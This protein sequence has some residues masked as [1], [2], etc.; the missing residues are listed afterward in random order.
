MAE[1]MQRGVSAP[2]GVWARVRADYLAGRS[3]SACARLH[4]VGVTT[5]R[6]RA[7]REGWRR[8]DHPWV[9]PARLD[10]ADEAA[11][12][13]EQVGGNLDKITFHDLSWLACRR[14]RRAVMRGDAA[15]ALRW[16]RVRVVM[17]AEQAE[18]LDILARFE[19]AT[20][21]LAALAPMDPMP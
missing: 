14:M 7:A 9:S 20:D 8:C 1:G 19:A 3:A 6:A 12:L 15:E 2:D 5:L 11:A 17:E 16:R 18:S 4:G 13:E 21:H 10:P